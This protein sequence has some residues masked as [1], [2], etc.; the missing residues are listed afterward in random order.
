MSTE[1]YFGWPINAYF[2]GFV[3][4]MPP[5]PTRGR[6][7]ELKYRHIVGK[8]KAEVKRKVKAHYQRWGW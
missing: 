6:D 5:K 8:T 3:S 2:D 4:A 7:G 1:S